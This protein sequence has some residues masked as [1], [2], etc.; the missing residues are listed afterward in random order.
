MLDL[1]KVIHSFNTTSCQNAASSCYKLIKENKAKSAIV[2]SIAVTS[3]S[4]LVSNSLRSKGCQYYNTVTGS[5]TYYYAKYFLKGSSS[6]EDLQKARNYFKIAADRGHVDAAFQLSAMCFNGTGGEKDEISGWI[7]Y[8]RWI[9]N[10]HSYTSEEYRQWYNAVNEEFRLG[11]KKLGD[12]GNIE[13][14]LRY[15]RMCYLG[16]GGD[17]DLVEA[18]KYFQL[19]ADEG[20]FLGSYVY[21]RMCFY[22]HGGEK[23][24]SE[25]LKYAENHYQRASSR[26]SVPLLSMILQKEGAHQDIERARELL[27]KHKYDSP[28]CLYQYGLMYFDGKIVEQDLET[29]F[30]SFLK[31]LSQAGEGH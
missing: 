22:G 5:V 4:F 8:K 12:E 11:L 1:Q 3:L 21:A 14:S 25:A 18:R 31:L 9:S 23:D 7:Y 17:K 30:N 27:I 20:Y 2:V 15:A 16:Q 24:L 29:A 28:S 10:Q 19:S 26:K 13:T 6:H